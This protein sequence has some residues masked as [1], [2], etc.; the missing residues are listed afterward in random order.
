[1][2]KK[3]YEGVLK[4]PMTMTG[5]NPI[6]QFYERLAAL[7]DHYGTTN[8][9]ELVVL[10]A[11]EYVPGF[12]YQKRPKNESSEARKETV[13]DIIIYCNLIEA[14]P[15]KVSEFARELA[16]NHS[17]WGYD[18]QYIRSRYNDMK[19]LDTKRGA[20]RAVKIGKLL[21]LIKSEL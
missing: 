4:E 15:N 7:E 11:R 6:S 18:W 1:M 5:E 12:S 2:T 14:P 20:D 13:I 21:E 17:E 10:L 8:H 3:P 19:R 16:D 9:S